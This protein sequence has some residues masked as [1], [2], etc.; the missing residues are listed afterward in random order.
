MS[1]AE[2]KF[3]AQEEAA[4]QAAQQKAK[5][6]KQAKNLQVKTNNKKPVAKW[7]KTLPAGGCSVIL[8]P[9][10]GRKKQLWYVVPLIKFLE[11]KAN[12]I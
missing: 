7:H 5:A 3:V 1:S 8:Y 11:Q 6:A 2:K 12:V 4:R 9:F 10:K